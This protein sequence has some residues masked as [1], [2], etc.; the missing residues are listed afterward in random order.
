MNQG[1]YIAAASAVFVI[2]TITATLLLTILGAPTVLNS[3]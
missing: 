3:P 1:R 2:A